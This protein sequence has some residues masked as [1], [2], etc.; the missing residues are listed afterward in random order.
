MNSLE[1]ITQRNSTQIFL[2]KKKATETP[3]TYKLS[4]KKIQSD[5]IG[6][7]IENDHSKIV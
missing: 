5:C 4:E 1:S 2:D 6:K 3:Q 7:P